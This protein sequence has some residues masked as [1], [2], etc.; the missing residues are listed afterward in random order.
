MSTPSGLRGTLGRAGARRLVDGGGGA[1]L[2]G[3]AVH[4]R[5]WSLVGRQR[6]PTP[7][8]VS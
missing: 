7:A 8:G 1:P 6:R 4:G 2:L 3:V 5:R